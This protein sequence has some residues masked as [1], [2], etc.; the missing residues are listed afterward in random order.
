M[1]IHLATLGCRLNEAEVEA[2]ARGFREAGHAIVDTADTADVLVLNSCAVTHEAT[3]KSRQTATRL[4]K[5]AGEA[6]LVLTGCFASLDKEKAAAVNGVDL[7]VDNADKDALVPLVIDALDLPSMPVQA[8][9]PDAQAIFP[10]RRTRAFVK[11]QDGCRNKCTFCIVTVARG[12]ERSRT[13]DD[14][15]AEVQALVRGGVQEVVLAGVHLGG[16][17]SDHGTDLGAL[18]QAVLEHTTVP[19]LRLGSL[20]PWE[21]PEGFFKLWQNPRLMPHL[22]LPL[23]SGSNAIL[24]RMARRC[25]MDEY[26]GLLADARTHV[27]DFE[28]T[29]DIIVGFPGESDAHFAE[30]LTAIDTLA[31]SHVHGFSYSPR[32]GTH[33]AT[34]KDQVHGGVKKERSK[35]LHAAAAASKAKRLAAYVGRTFDVLVENTHTKDGV[36]TAYGYTPNFLRVALDVPDG[37]ALDNCIL[38]VTLERVTGKQD[39]LRGTA[40]PDAMYAAREAAASLGG[41]P[42]GKARLGVLQ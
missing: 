16:Y 2:W 6:K 9:A 13:I 26:S 14:V 30:T 39:M 5:K 4:H 25:Y 23:Q 38:P 22:H 41:T 3:R 36:T 7:V 8:E 40:T 37:A 27:P 35:A 19:R 12:E 28:I 20:E 33:A 24:K 32:E 42:R 21:L 18:I 34:R 31:F 15:V 11:V 1:N 29:T 17:G 10:T